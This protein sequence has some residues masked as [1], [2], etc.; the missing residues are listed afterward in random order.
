MQDGCSYLVNI[1]KDKMHVGALLRT[2]KILFILEFLWCTRLARP[3]EDIIIHSQTTNEF[4][5]QELITG[6]IRPLLTHH[7]TSSGF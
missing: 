1:S 6:S 2:Y 3:I 5:V 7:I 4:A